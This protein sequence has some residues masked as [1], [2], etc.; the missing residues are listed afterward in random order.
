MLLVIADTSPIRYLA[1]IGHIELLQRL[2]ERISIPVEVAKELSDPSTPPAAH[3][4]IE[5]P[6]AWLNVCEA[7]PTND[8]QLLGLDIGERSAIA[9]GVSIRADLI[10]IDDRKGA[11]MARR[12]GF[13]TTGTLGVLD[14]AARRGLIDLA[15]AF[16]RLKQTNFRYKQEIIDAILMRAKRLE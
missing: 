9:L 15:D 10:L 3:A 4:W 7:P 8:P 2:F 1:Q 13:E 6:P 11:L 16:G 5:A 12:K 14:L